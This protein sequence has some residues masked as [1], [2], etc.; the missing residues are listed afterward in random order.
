MQSR[1][2]ER[3][4]PADTG[5]RS[6]CTWTHA[7]KAI[8]WSTPP[9]HF[10]AFLKP[11]CQHGFG[12]SV[13]PL[14]VPGQ[15]RSSTELIYALNPLLFNLGIGWLAGSANS[16]CTAGPWVIF[17]GCLIW[18][19]LPLLRIFGIRIKH[20]VWGPPASEYL[21]R[22]VKH[23]DSWSPP[24]TYWFAMRMRWGIVIS[25]LNRSS[26]NSQ[27]VFCLLTLISSPPPSL[28][29][30]WEAGMEDDENISFGTPLGL[31]RQDAPPLYS[32]VMCTWLC[33]S[34]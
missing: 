4:A 21:G 26:R 34:H 6:Q 32:W 33:Y 8:C 13:Q 29:P 12:V 3:G 14:E 31:P 7:L 1:G 22:L 16:Q 28:Q 9:S 25:F 19:L 5:W 30:F 11:A 20:V 17:S 24:Q 2:R 18:A 27:A 23:A 15:E 10:A